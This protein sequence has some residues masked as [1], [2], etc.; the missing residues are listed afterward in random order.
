MSIIMASKKIKSHSKE[1]WVKVP[2]KAKTRYNDYY[3]SDFGRIKSVSKLSGKEKLLKGARDIYGNPK[4]SISVVGS[5]TRQVVY[6]HLLV[7]NE[8]LKPPTPEHK[9]IIRKDNN[10]ENNHYKNLKWMTQEEVIKHHRK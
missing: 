4:I 7:G 8:F 1:R 3:F 9:F 5:N 2:T 6:L 10:K